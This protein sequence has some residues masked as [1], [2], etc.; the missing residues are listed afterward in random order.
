[1]HN[2]RERGMSGDTQERME[3]MQFKDWVISNDT[4]ARDVLKRKEYESEK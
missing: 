4:G 2:D 3:R 1:L